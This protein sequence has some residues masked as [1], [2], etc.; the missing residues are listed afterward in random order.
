MS[1][2][3]SPEAAFESNFIEGQTK[4]YRF[5]GVGKIT[6]QFLVQ[7]LYCQISKLKISKN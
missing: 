5:D 2:P 4:T 1:L 6:T 7:W 3:A